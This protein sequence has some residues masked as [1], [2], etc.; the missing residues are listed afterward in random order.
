MDR[1]LSNVY[2]QRFEV[3]EGDMIGIDFLLEAMEKVQLI[4]EILRTIQSQQKSYNYVKRR[5]IK[6]EVGYWLFLKVSYMKVI[7]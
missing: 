4:R 7:M 2:I 5:E 6:F 3:G 1:N